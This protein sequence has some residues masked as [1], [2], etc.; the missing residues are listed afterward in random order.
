MSEQ[1]FINFLYPGIFASKHSQIAIE[2]KQDGMKRAKEDDNCFGFYFSSRP[3]QVEQNK[4]L[5]GPEKC[6]KTT[7]FIGQ[8]CNRKQVEETGPD[9][10]TLLENMDANKLKYVVQTRKGN[11]QEVDK[12]TIV[13]NEK[14]NQIYPPLLTP[15]HAQ[16]R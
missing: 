11:F 2:T 4:R 3:Y 6:D 13:L 9:N 10:G 7:Y 15:A 14:F 5:Y 16:H 8:I 1:L 12:D